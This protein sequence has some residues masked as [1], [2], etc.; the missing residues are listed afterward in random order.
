MTDLFFIGLQEIEGVDQ[1]WW[2]K[3]LKFKPAVFSGS[4]KVKTEIGHK[5][6][7][8]RLQ[9]RPCSEI[10]DKP[11]LQKLLARKK[12]LRQA[13]DRRKIKT[14]RSTP[15]RIQ[16]SRSKKIKYQNIKNESPSKF[17]RESPGSSS[18]RSQ[19]QVCGICFSSFTSEK[20]LAEH[21]KLHKMGVFCP[22][23]H[24]FYSHYGDMQNHVLMEHHLIPVVD[25]YRSLTCMKCGD[26]FTGRKSLIDHLFRHH[27]NTLV[28]TV[29]KRIFSSKKM[30]KNHFIDCHI[31]K[32]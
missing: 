20:S 15:S 14:E 8:P 25:K 30:M 5:M 17:S 13:E 21:R 2:S 4:V 24:K 10:D 19:G 29:C 26:S 9:I 7:G 11:Q 22:V 28:C 27:Y 16:P 3:E 12:N 18:L 6:T 31:Q 1:D 32:A 23:C